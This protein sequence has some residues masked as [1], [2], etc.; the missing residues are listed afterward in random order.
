MSK[1]IIPNIRNLLFVLLAVSLPFSVSI[2]N[3]LVVSLLLS[4]ILEG[5]FITK[6]TRIKSSKWMVS[7]SLLLILYYLS[8]FIYGQFSDTIWLLKRV[9]ILWILPILY[10]VF[11]PIKIIFKSLFAFLFSMFLSSVIA[12]SE[13]IKLIN[14]NGDNWTWAAFLKYTDHNVFLASSIIISIFS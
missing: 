13:N 7:L 12:I 9:S 5:G 6:V 4:V 1:T 2:S 8:F 3:I 14:I 11:F 10:S